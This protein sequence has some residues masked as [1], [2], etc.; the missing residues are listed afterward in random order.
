[1]MAARV[2][3]MKGFACRSVMNPTT[4]NGMMFMIPYR[5]MHTSKNK[6][7]KLQK[8]NSN[9][10]IINVNN[11]N[12]Q[13]NPTNMGSLPPPP[14]YG[15]NNPQFEKGQLAGY[16]FIKAL[17]MQTIRTMPELCYVMLCYVMLCYVM[18]F[19]VKN[20]FKIKLY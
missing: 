12:N 4:K 18:Y 20:V 7:N 17:L 15:T 2:I 9:K 13:Q 8:Q 5:Q 6:Q 11:N 19:K 14:S 1:M 3:A 16:D 10:N